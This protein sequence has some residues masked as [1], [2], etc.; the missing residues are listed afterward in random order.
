MNIDSNLWCAEYSKTQDCYNI[1]IL[2][3]ILQRNIQNTI[4]KANND[5]Q[6]IEI[7]S[8]N[9]CQEFIEAIKGSQNNG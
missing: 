1:E 9:K 2:D 6:I 8:Y 5:Y 3:N 7:G 4:R